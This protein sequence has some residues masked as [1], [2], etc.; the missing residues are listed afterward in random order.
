MSMLM[1][2]PGPLEGGPMVSPGPA[3]E[4]GEP[5]SAQ[6]KHAF[7][8]SVGGSSPEA[9]KPPLDRNLSPAKER[10]PKDPHRDSSKP[11]DQKTT[12][13]DNG[14]THPSKSDERLTTPK[15]PQPKDEGVSAKSSPD[16]TPPLSQSKWEN[17]IKGSE[18]MVEGVPLI[19]DLETA[20]FGGPAEGQ[21]LSPTMTPPESIPLEGE[22]NT[23]QEGDVSLMLLAPAVSENMPVPPSAFPE[24]AEVEPESEIKD[25]PLKKQLSLLEGS[26]PVL[27]VA[28]LP[29]IVPLEPIVMVEVDLSSAPLKDDLTIA[30]VAT[31][32]K[33]DPLPLVDEK[34]E[35]TNTPMEISSPME[36]PSL[37]KAN[38]SKKETNS[39]PQKK[40]ETLSPPVLPEET[41]KSTDVPALRVPVE[42]VG[43]QNRAESEG[44]SSK[45][46]EKKEVQRTDSTPKET[47]LPTAVFSPE[48]TAPIL[49]TTDPLTKGK[50]APGIAAVQ[51]GSMGSSGSPVP[52][53]GGSVPRLSEVS[54]GAPAK[55]A[56]ATAPSPVDLARQIHVHLESGRSVVR[57]ELHPEHLGE[58]RI[59]LETKGKDVSMQF[60]VD[61][62][63][64]RTAV[65]AGLREITGTLSTLG[66]SVSGLAVNVSSGGV[67]NGRGESNG[68]FWG[69]GQKISNNILPEPKTASPHRETGQWRVDLV[70]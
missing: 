28:G 64:A 37:K 32:P 44:S 57:I 59:S 68:P 15:G 3:K 45:G 21:V 35:S 10:P 14:P 27:P 4:S 22:Q 58:L 18:M 65:V 53:M 29:T 47:K 66:W 54:D 48:G 33:N 7:D 13:K 60:T 40:E 24:E 26:I 20:L 11:T 55:A 36:T 34:K 52:E 50:N 30:P 38:P 70:A 41:K 16:K 67:G 23:V 42:P 69:E 43:K 61:N 63:N 31:E 25:E 9:P 17:P 5:F 19:S 2:R 56:P 39:I 6:L 62:D 8:Q 49:K 12:V 51:S 1:V 46:L